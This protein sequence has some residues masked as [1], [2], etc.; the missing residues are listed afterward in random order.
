MARKI[1]N[2]KCSDLIDENLKTIFQ[3]E[4]DRDLPDR[5]TNLIEQLRA[6]D[7]VT[8]QNRSVK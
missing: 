3:Q 7:A 4:V 5:F 6:K 1:E 2:G 8:D